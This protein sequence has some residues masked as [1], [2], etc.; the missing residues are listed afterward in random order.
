[1]V[2]M[3][4]R[5][6]ITLA[7]LASLLGFGASA[8]T[9]GDKPSEVAAVASQDTCSNPQGWE[10]CGNGALVQVNCTPCDGCYSAFCDVYVNGWCCDI[11]RNR[12]KLIGEEADLVVADA[13]G[14]L[15]TQDRMQDSCPPQNNCCTHENGVMIDCRM[16]DGSL[17]LIWVGQLHEACLVTD[18]PLV[19]PAPSVQPAPRPVVLPTSLA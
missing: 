5:T 12:C 14:L 9:S 11:T 17:C 4:L 1:M 18:P 16:D 8:A 10:C 7:L 6:T 19:A 13:N 15:A 3:R 2:D